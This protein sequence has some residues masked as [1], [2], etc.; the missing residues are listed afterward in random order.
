MIKWR[1]YRI[2][3]S[4]YDKPCRHTSNA[5]TI[6]EANITSAHMLE[7]NAKEPVGMSKVDAA[8]PLGSGKRLPTGSKRRRARTAAAIAV[9]GPALSPR[10][11]T[12]ESHRGSDS[13]LGMGSL[14]CSAWLL[15]SRMH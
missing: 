8:L 1:A 7:K 15:K 5:D 13:T 12:M 4:G 6:P 10:P 14:S 3:A 2:P 11:R 9:W